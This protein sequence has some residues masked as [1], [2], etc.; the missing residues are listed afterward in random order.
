[1]DGNKLKVSSLVRLTDRCRLGHKDR[2]LLR[3]PQTAV[4]FKCGD[5]D[6]LEGFILSLLGCFDYKSEKCLHV[7]QAN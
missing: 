1:M 5:A 7:F 4:K 3:S 6:S 2:R